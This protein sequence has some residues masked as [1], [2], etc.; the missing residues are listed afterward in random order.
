MTDE[1][2]RDTALVADFVRRLRRVALH[3]LALD[4]G[5]GEQIPMPGESGS[6]R[7][8]L[9]KNPTPRVPGRCQWRSADWSVSSTIPHTGLL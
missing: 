3:P 1:R 5:V 7:I 4:D 8:G 2:E 9:P 6:M